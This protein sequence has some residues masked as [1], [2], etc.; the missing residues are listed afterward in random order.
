MRFFIFHIFSF[1]LLFG[2]D[3]AGNII[4][5]RGDVFV[6]RNFETLDIEENYEILS[7]DIIV[8]G[9]GAKAKIK[10][11]DD[12]LVT[13]GKN[14]IFEIEDYFFDKSKNSKMNF[15]A[16]NG[17]FS[18]VSGQIG[19]VAPENFALKT[20]TATIGIRGTAFEGEVS[21]TK[22]SVSCTKGAIA[23]SAK[24][25]TIIVNA[26]ETLEIK[27]E[28]FKADVDV[29]VDVI[30]TIKSMEGVIFIIRDGKTFIPSLGE[31]IK[32]ADKIATAH[33]SKVKIELIE[34]ADLEVLFNS[35]CSLNYENGGEKIE[36]LKGAVKLISSEKYEYLKSGEKQMV[37]SGK[38]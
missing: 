9:D 14:S 20:K 34:K 32:P 5:K 29:D 1:S 23:V 10:F 30:G 38:W 37:R 21:P 22:E 36:V 11:K 18:A 8:T 35:A 25:K 2:E 13:V 4:Q 28:L 15:K 17:F 19:K 12:T 6:V 24:G 7:K 3:I 26:G 31:N 16:K 33:D 27:E